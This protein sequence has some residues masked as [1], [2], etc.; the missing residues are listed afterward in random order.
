MRRTVIAFDLYGTLLSTESISEELTML[1]GQDKAQSVATLA[2][3]YQLESTWRANSMG[4]YR[5]FSELTRWSFRQAT[6][7]VGV[8]LTSEQEERIMDAYDGLDTF[9]DV[10][11]ALKK[12]EDNASLDPYIFSN[13]TKA[14][15]TSSLN[16]SS[17][18]SQ[19]SNVFPH[20]KLVSI[21]S[22]RVFKPD[23]RT[24][25]FM[26]QIAGLESQ[27]GRIWLV[28]SNPFDVVGATAV[29]LKSAWID[30]EGKGWNDTLGGSLG[31]EPTVMASGVDEAVQVIL[32]QI[33]D[34]E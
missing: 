24:Y 28:S 7:E 9:P 33:E 15:I 5:S 13:G 19:A 32:H 21:D 17:S 11:D 22:L 29:G 1:F 14:M 27:P 23:P 6:K 26:A 3:R 34:G 16:T 30:R 31:L 8:E 4:I 12:L 25:K 10:D 2:R 18:L 20:Q